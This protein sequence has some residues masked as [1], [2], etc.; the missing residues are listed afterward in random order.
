MRTY[1]LKNNKRSYVLRLKNWSAPAI[2]SVL[3]LICMFII[4]CCET[5]GI[6]HKESNLIYRLNTVEKQ[7]I[8]TQLNE[9]HLLNKEKH[10]L[11]VN[12]YIYNKEQET[13]YDK[14]INIISSGMIDQLIYE[15]S[16]VNNL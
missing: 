8:N 10:N 16:N 15:K 7:F 13:K 5:L 11:S 2:F 9:Y 12:N 4:Y 6:A 1:S 14:R 3:I